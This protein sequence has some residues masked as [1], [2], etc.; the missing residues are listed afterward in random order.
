[1]LYASQGD[2]SR[3]IPSLKSLVRPLRNALSKFNVKV[4]LNVLVVRIIIVP[5][6]R[7]LQACS[8]PC[9]VRVVLQAL[10][11]LVQCA[12]GIGEAMTPYYKQFLQPMNTFLDQ[13]KNLGDT[14]DYGQVSECA[15]ELCVCDCVVL[16][17]DSHL[18][19]CSN[20]PLSS[21]GTITTSAKK[22][23]SLLK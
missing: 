5:H 2:A 6:C 4:L 14:I 16:W 22:C 12:D 3:V 20:L 11:Q 13:H 9:V 7:T 1:M 8:C 21:S 18:S 17:C 15:A 19:T 23:D 10:R